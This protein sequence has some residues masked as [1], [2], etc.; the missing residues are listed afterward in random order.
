M[1]IG[2][3]INKGDKLQN[4]QPLRTARPARPSDVFGATIDSFR[5]NDAFL[6]GSKIFR[7]LIEERNDRVRQIANEP[8][9]PNPFFGGFGDLI[10]QISQEGIIPQVQ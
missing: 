1:T 4:T 6:G 5:D 3:F 8:L 2:R 9:G 10:G 7:G